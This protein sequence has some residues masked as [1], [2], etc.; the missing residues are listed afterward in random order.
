M[1][2]HLFLTIYELFR[3]N[4]KDNNARE[5]PISLKNIRKGDAAWSTHKVILG[6]AIDTA[7]QALKIAK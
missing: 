3:L 5:E 7:K 1:T 6:W 2:Q 4:T